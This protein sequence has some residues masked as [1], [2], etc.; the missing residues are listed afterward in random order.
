MKEKKLVSDVYMN[1]FFLRVLI[2]IILFSV[3]TNF[4]GF[5]YNLKS[6][7]VSNFHHKIISILGTMED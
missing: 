7:N 3:Y 2:H 5:S 1:C 6:R 4:I